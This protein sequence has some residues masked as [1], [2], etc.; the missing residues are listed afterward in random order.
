M[1]WWFWAEFSSTFGLQLSWKISS[2]IVLR[3]FLLGNSSSWWQFRKS[4]VFYCSLCW[5]S[6][7]S[8][9]NELLL[10][11]FLYFFLGCV[12]AVGV[13][14]F[15]WNIFFRYCSS[16]IPPLG[17]VWVLVHSFGNLQFSIVVCACFLYF[18]SGMSCYCWSFWI[19]LECFLSCKFHQGPL[20]AQWRCRL[21]CRGPKSSARKCW[22]PLQSGSQKNDGELGQWHLGRQ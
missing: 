11:E 5:F 16:E 19:L 4:S 14:E 18:L 20:T 8:F 12:V 6:V 2:D 13:S 1:T 15:F 3:K 21:R 9:W 7:F 10:V 17:T 22:L